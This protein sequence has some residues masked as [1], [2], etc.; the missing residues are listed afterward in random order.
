MNSRI[1]I[2]IMAHLRVLE[3]PSLMICIAALLNTVGNRDL[4]TI[5]IVCAIIRLFINIRFKVQQDKFQSAILNHLD[6]IIDD[7]EEDEDGV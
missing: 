3:V 2:Q 7:M 4:F 5:V 1:V 6:D